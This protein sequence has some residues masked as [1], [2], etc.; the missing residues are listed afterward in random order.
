MP[1]HLTYL[2]RGVRHACARTLLLVGIAGASTPVAGQTAPGP[3]AN[4]DGVVTAAI[5]LAR[6]GPPATLT[7]ANRP[8]VELRSS[9]LDRLP[10]ERAAAGKATLDR[11]VGLGTF[12]PAQAR[13]VGPAVS[14]EVSGQRIV[15]ILPTDVDS[16]SGET[17]E[18][19][20]AAAAERLQLA[21]NEVAELQR[22]RQLLNSVVQVLGATALFGTLF[23]LLGKVRSAIRARIRRMTEQLQAD[24][25]PD[26]EFV[27]ASRLMEMPDRLVGAIPWIG[28]GFLAYSWL[29]FTLRRF[30]Y[31]RPWGESLRAYL[32]GELAGMGAEIMKA[33]PGLFTV[34]IIVLITRFVIRLVQLLFAA[35]EEGRVKLPWVYPE[36]ARPT[37]KLLT[38]GLWLFAVVLAYPY[39]PGSGSDA[40]KGM[41]VFIGLVVSLGSSGIMNQL[42][43]GFM[44]TYSRALRVG[45]IVNVG[46]VEGAVAELGSLSTKIKTLR[47]E[48]VTI[49]NAVVVSNTVINYSRF[50]ESDGVFVATDVTLGYDVP[51]RQVEALLLIAA[52]RSAG[53]RPTP[54]PRVRLSKLEDAYI[55]YTLLFCPDQPD[56]RRVT[57]ANV[58][59]N[60]LDAFNEY[61]VQITSPNYEA[62]PSHP[63]LVPPDQWFAAP[64]RPAPEDSPTVQELTIRV[65]VD[66]VDGEESRSTIGRPRSG[67]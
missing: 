14:L 11:L 31:T 8:I 43:S 50:A 6:P 64:A 7:Y 54:E 49:P 9:L 23:W 63:K 40:F 21:L 60:I 27:R 34:A 16:L 25:I 36:T 41:S 17:P 28:G 19:A 24:W 51:W 35:F 5:A 53:V 61:G 46:E 65:A 55:R 62:D 26:A 13:S 15:A 22:P 45:D 56:G 67:G 44:I 38:A 66:A 12:G 10:A 2:P 1:T 4:S 47:G 33:L 20:G 3:A 29:T 37:R 39:L 57:L 52:T 32:L 48:D 18:A 59:K 42:I 58:H 30:P